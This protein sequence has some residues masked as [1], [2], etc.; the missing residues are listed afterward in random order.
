MEQRA[1]TLKGR[2]RQG[3]VEDLRCVRSSDMEMFALDAK[4]DIRM[5]C[6]F[7]N[8]RSAQQIGLVP[9]LSQR[10]S[11]SL[12]LSPCIT[13]RAIQDTGTGSSK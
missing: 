5:N 10:T 3:R 11:A 1:E 7:H 2:L 12:R 6:L 13:N 9:A 8:R 4:R